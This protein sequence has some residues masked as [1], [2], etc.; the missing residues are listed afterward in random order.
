MKTILL[1]HQ[2][3]E[4]YG[5]DKS[6]LN[7]IKYLKNYY[8]LIVLIPEDGPLANELK[9]NEVEYHIIDLLKISRSSLSINFFLSALLRIPRCLKNLSKI[10][11]NRHIDIVY[12]NT[13]AVIIG[14][15]WAK[16]NNK[17]HIWHI[18]EIISEPKAVKVFYSLI[19]KKLSN[20]ILCN[21]KA[22]AN[23]IDDKSYNKIQVIYNG[24]NDLNQNQKLKKVK[25]TINISLIGRINKWKGHFLFV[26]VANKLISDGVKNIKF[27]IIGSPHK[28]NPS[29]LQELEQ[30]IKEFDIQG[31][32]EIIEFQKEI[33]NM[34][35]KSDI[36]VV[37][38][39]KPE[40]FGLVAIEAMSFGLPVIGTNMGGLKEIIN[41]GETG[42]LFDFNSSDDFKN[43]L[44]ILIDDETLRLKLGE[45]GRNRYK[46]LFQLENNLKNI[47]NVFDS[48]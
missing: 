24:V 17:Y 32:I 33:R 7:T 1:F 16:I 41:H 28:S 10:I 39:I 47:K 45:N 31:Y 3:G 6:I 37:P 13:I 12:T 34:Y 20:K 35:L 23:N 38:S 26:D 22:T 5:S 9:K 14:A 30:Y 25:D 36:V 15:I 44:Q 27:S 19:V 2:S 46:K 11:K 21:S 4:L 40:P 42:Y 18:R 43:Y 8:N 48:I 29:I